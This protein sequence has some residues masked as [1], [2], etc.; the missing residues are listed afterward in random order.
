M[1][2]PADIDAAEAHRVLAPLVQRSMTVREARAELT[3]VARVYASRDLKVARAVLFEV[4]G[5]D[6]TTVDEVI[7]A[8]V[9]ANQ[10]TPARD[11]VRGI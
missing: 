4:T 11:V 10:L 6:T 9:Y 5:Q 8:L 1:T 3:A 7:T 2:N